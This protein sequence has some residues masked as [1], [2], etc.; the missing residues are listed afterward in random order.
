MP[1]LSF[2]AMDRD[3]AR[4]GN[5]VSAAS[6]PV[7]VLVCCLWASVLC[8]ANPVAQDLGR[9][10]RSIE[11]GPIDIARLT[12]RA[13]VVVHGSIT[14]RT[15]RWIGRVI[16]TQY[17]VAVQETLKGAARSTVTVAVPGGALGNV[18]LTVPGAPELEVGAELVFFGEPLQGETAFT[19][20]GTF[21]G[22]VAIRRT[23]G[24]ATVAPRGRP[25]ALDAFLEE[26]RTLGRRP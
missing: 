12:A 25:E 10:G 7:A 11:A 3:A 6:H 19:P 26:V 16:Y 9:G 21:D 1:D 18:Q 4:S 2:V 22:L 23:S 20:V 5:R 13:A 17:D 8:T 15:T 24:P 14:N